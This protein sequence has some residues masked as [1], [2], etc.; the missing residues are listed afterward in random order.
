MHASWN[1][2][3]FLKL[4][5]IY[6]K[7]PEGLKPP[8]SRDMVALALELH[9]HP[10]FLYEKMELLAKPRSR[11]FRALATRYKGHPRLLVNDIRKRDQLAGFGLGDAFFEG[12][13]I[14]ETFERDF[15]PAVEGS[16]VTPMM[17]VIIFNLYF[18]MLPPMISPGL[19]EVVALAKRLRIS[20]D[21]MSEVMLSLLDADPYYP[22][23]SHE[24]KFAAVCHDIFARYCGDGHALTEDEARRLE[25]DAAAMLEYFPKQ[26]GRRKGSKNATPAE[27]KRKK[28]TATKKSTA[29][30]KATRK[31]Q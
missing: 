20:P 12:V 7:R 27:R 31:R 3:Y 5:Q 26:G 4:F 29:A 6:M 11:I 13:E 24:S 10:E 2:E 17:V 28:R 19:P 25:R 9:I 22:N 18:H 30:K 14:E 21:E 16:D 8:Y 1:Y 23:Y 15:R